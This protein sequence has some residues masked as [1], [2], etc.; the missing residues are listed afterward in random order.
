MK[1]FVLRASSAT[2]V[3]GLAA[4]CGRAVTGGA[5]A[6]PAPAAGVLAAK[7]AVKPAV[8]V[9]P[10]G[11]TLAMIARGDSLYS[12][13][14]CQRCHGPWG[15]NGPNG[16]ALAK[17]DSAKWLHSDGSYEGIVATILRG[18]PRDSLVDKTRRFQMNPRGSNPPLSDEDVRAVA[19][20]VWKLNHP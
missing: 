18:V 3:V 15:F 14:A 4:A 6:S 12:H 13:N 1:R 11:V 19:A 16:P 10:A 20:Y 8:P 9:L 2:C 17:G 7:P 5:A